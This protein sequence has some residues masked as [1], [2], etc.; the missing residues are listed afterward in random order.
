V[1]SHVD[2]K[3]C[4]LDCSGLGCDWLEERWLC[5]ETAET[6]GM[7][8]G[9]QS[10]SSRC[11]TSSL[12]LAQQRWTCLAASPVLRVGLSNG[13]NLD[14]RILNMSFHR[15]IGYGESNRQRGWPGRRFCRIQKK[16]CKSSYKPLKKDPLRASRLL[17]QAS[18]SCVW[19]FGLTIMECIDALRSLAQARLW[20]SRCFSSRNCTFLDS[21]K[22]WRRSRSV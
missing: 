10:G 8:E 4:R 14:Q 7:A 21:N 13:P 15:S 20:D 1:F 5:L 3:A 18:L 12:L 19:A 16:A 22:H 2:G 9:S 11:E 17:S 6:E